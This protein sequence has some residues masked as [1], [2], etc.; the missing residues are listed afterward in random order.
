MPALP[1]STSFWH[2][3]KLNRETEACPSDAGVQRP[4]ASWDPY[5]GG[6]REGGQSQFPIGPLQPGQWGA[7]LRQGAAQRGCASRPQRDSHLRVTM[8]E[9]GSKVALQAAGSSPEPGNESFT[10]LPILCWPQASN[11]LSPVLVAL[12]AALREC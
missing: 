6:P 4:L 8:V 9:P 3:E 10:P 7:D 1:T 5:L 11:L 2:Q 12:A